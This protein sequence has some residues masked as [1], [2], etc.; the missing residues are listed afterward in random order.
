VVN[1]REKETLE[2]D[3]QDQIIDTLEEQPF[4]FNMIQILDM[5]DSEFKG[6]MITVPGGL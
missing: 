2:S 4:S 1:F 3:V 5:D 6:H